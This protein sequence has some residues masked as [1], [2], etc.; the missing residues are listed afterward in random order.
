MV[1]EIYG[2]DVRQ[3]RLVSVQG[4]QNLPA[5]QRLKVPTSVPKCRH[6]YTLF[7]LCQ[8]GPLY[9]FKSRCFPR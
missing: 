9:T 5:G 1:L 4:D 2:Y 6:L 8:D 3:Q 7:G